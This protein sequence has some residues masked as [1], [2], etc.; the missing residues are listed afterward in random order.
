LNKKIIKKNKNYTYDILKNDL[1]FLNYEYPFFKINNIGKSTLGENIIY[2]KLGEGNKKLFINSSHHANEWMTSLIIMMFIEKYLYLYKNKKIY[3]TYNIEELWNRT[4]LYIVPMV[5]PDGV[6]L[7]LREKRILNNLEYKNIWEKYKNKLEDWKANIRGVDINLN[8][9]AGWEQ[10]VINK[11]KKG[12]NSL[13]PRDYPG[14]N[15]VSEIETK[16]M[17]HFSN[18]FNFDMTISLHSQGQEIYGYNKIEKAYEIGKKMER[19]SGYLLTE[20]EY[21]SAF[22]G[23]KDW[24]IQEFNK[25]AFTIE[26][27]KGEEGKSLPLK[28]AEKIYNEIEEIFFIALEEC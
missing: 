20:P 19:A 1:L 23:Y 21:Y 24:F 16:N 5:N 28:D 15:A 14:P 9:P 12:I 3:K 17:I 8:Y 27:G 2:I 26:I 11:R 25:P 6:N 7:C 4:S 18:L 22:A 10:A 13:G